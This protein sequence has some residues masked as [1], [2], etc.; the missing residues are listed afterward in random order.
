LA[1]A[2]KGDKSNHHRLNGLQD[3]AFINAGQDVSVKV[4]AYDYTVFGDLAGH[5]RRISADT[6][7]N[8]QG[9]SFYRVT[10]EID[11][12]SIDTESNPLPLIPGMDVT[13][14]KLTGQQ[15]VAHYLVSTIKRAR[16]EALRER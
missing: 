7:E 14:D 8:E 12:N 16:N 2:G 15:A 1:C 5:V 3:I 10:V 6:F 13:V 4:I 11:E 9:E